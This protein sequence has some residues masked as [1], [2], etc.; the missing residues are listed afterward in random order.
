MGALSVG[1]VRTGTI[2]SLLPS[3][4]HYLKVYRSLS[5]QRTQRSQR[6]VRGTKQSTWIHVTAVFS[7]FLPWAEQETLLSVPSVSSVAK[8]SL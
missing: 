3:Q 4:K 7:P 5:P 1:D 8:D 6:L 2:P